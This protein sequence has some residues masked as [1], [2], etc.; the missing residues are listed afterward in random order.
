MW[1]GYPVVM[2]ENKPVDP[3]ISWLLWR[4]TPPVGWASIIFLSISG[5]LLFCARKLGDAADEWIGGQTLDAGV[6]LHELSGV[7]A[8]LAETFLGLSSV[9]FFLALVQLRPKAL[10]RRLRRQSTFISRNMADTALILT[11]MESEIRSR[12][13][14]LQLYDE[15]ERL[16]DA[17]VERLVQRF[18][19]STLLGVRTNWIVGAVFFVASVAV[20]VLLAMAMD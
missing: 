11:S 16:K 19:K 12:D 9:G 4:M 17:E 13:E 2:S 18:H 5:L 20:S 14:Q 6:I 1:S 8:D 10:R 7:T 15:L 3:P